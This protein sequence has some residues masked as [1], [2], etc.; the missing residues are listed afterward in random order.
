MDLVILNRG[1]EDEY[2]TPAGNHLS[3][4]PHHT[5][6]RSI[7]CDGFSVYQTRLEG[8]SSIE[9]GLEPGTLLATKLYHQVIEVM[10]NKSV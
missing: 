5:S 8:G 6:G 10:S 2:D 1:S 7:G 9:S 4:L 3:K